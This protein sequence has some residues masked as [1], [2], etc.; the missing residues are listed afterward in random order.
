MRRIESKAVLLKRRVKTVQTKAIFAGLLYLVGLIALTALT[1]IFPTVKGAA[2]NGIPTI[3][4]SW[5]YGKVE[6]MVAA[7]AKAIANSPVE[8]LELLLN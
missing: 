3:G 1:A 5:G 6:D 7:G 8:L 4:V 2:V